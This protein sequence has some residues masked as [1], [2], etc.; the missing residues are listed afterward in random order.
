LDDGSDSSA[1]VVLPQIDPNGTLSF[2]PAPTLVQLSMNPTVVAVDSDGATSDPQ[3][4]TI[5]I[6]P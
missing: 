3:N 6:N 4:F 1:F 5:T 2:T